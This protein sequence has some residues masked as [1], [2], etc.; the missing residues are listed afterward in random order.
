[1]GRKFAANIFTLCLTGTVS[2]RQLFGQTGVLRIKNHTAAKD[3]DN[4]FKEWGET[5]CGRVWAAECASLFMMPDTLIAQPPCDCLGSPSG[6]L[7]SGLQ[8]HTTCHLRALHERPFPLPT[9]TPW[10]WEGAG[11]FSDSDRSLNHQRRRPISSYM[12]AR[13]FNARPPPPPPTPSL[14]T[15]KTSTSLRSGFS[16]SDL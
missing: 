1:M 10:G 12:S 4:V 8:G 16:T 15:I 6:Q 3:C 11:L 5:V 14:T 2:S 9:N 7:V 13:R